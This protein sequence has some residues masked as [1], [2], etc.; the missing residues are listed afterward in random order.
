MPTK[1]I[2]FDSFTDIKSEIGP[3]AVK[4]EPE[5]EMEIDLLNNANQV[6]KVD[7]I[8]GKDMIIADTVIRKVELNNEFNQSATSSTHKS[9]S[10]D[11]DSIDVSILCM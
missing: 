9:K 4:M 3:L 8:D 11:E 1:K 6:A 2:A 5:W 10:F 7:A